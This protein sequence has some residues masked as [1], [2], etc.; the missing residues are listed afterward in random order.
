MLGADIG[1][2]FAVRSSASA[3]HAQKRGQLAGQARLQPN[4]GVVPANGNLASRQPRLDL[5]PDLAARLRAER[6]VERRRM[7][8]ADGPAQVSAQRRKIFVAV[9]VGALFAQNAVPLAVPVAREGKGDAGVEQPGVVEQVVTNDVYLST[10]SASNSSA[11]SWPTRSRAWAMAVS[12]SA[13]VMVKSSPVY[14]TPSSFCR[15]TARGG[16]E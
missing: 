11:N 12:T 4:L 16:S 9:A 6:I 10:S 3:Q 14:S 13:S 5:R 7:L 8:R 2:P 15:R 1:Q